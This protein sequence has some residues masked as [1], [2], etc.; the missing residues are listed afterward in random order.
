M[1]HVSSSG[2]VSTMASEYSDCIEAVDEGDI[3]SGSSGAQDPQGGEE[4]SRIPMPKTQNWSEMH[5][6]EDR[7]APTTVMIRNVPSRY[8]KRDLTNDLISLGFSGTFD[9]LYIP[10]DSN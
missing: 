6:N 9:F 5:D 7:D 3:S 8:S 1:R 4:C 10:V 2:S